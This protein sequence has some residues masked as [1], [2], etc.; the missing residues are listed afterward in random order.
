M[1]EIEMIEMIEVI[2]MTEKIEMIESR[3]YS[4]TWVDES[5]VPSEFED[6]R[7]LQREHWPQEYGEIIGEGGSGF[8]VSVEN[9]AETTWV[10]VMKFKQAR[11]HGGSNYE[12]SECQSDEIQTSAGTR[13]E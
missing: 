8:E 1:T 3:L 10:K 6:Q 11:V 5:V 9:V 7:P 4:S 13:W 12:R 2:E